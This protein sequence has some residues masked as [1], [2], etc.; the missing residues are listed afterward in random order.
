MGKKSRNSENEDT[1]NL[2]SSFSESREHG[3]REE[4]GSSQISEN[5][6]NK[7]F[8]SSFSDIRELPSSSL[9]TQQRSHHVHEFLKMNIIYDLYLHFRKFMKAHK[10]EPFLRK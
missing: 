5:E 3:G 6:D 2:L 1:N 7:L 8:V 4:D 10:N 9:S